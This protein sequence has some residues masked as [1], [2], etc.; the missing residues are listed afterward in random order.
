MGNLAC[1]DQWILVVVIWIVATVYWGD[2]KLRK[3]VINDWVYVF[4]RVVSGDGGRVVGR[5]NDMYLFG[6]FLFMLGG[7][8]AEEWGDHRKKNFL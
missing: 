4:P 2:L 5:W 6:G 3:L 8:N 1:G 7:S